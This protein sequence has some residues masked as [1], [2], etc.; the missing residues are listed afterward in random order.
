MAGRLQNEVGSGE[1][2]S[3]DRAIDQRLIV[4]RDP[5]VPAESRSGSDDATILGPS[6]PQ[7]LSFDSK[8]VKGVKRRAD[9]SVE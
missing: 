3:T 8:A 2:R 6:P 4:G 5:Q 9:Q 1:A 7:G